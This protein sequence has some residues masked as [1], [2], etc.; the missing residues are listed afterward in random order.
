MRRVVVALLPCVAGSVYFFGWRSLVMVLVSWACAFAAEYLFCRW[1]REP[2]SEAV[3]V[4]ATILALIM[5]PSIPWHVLA[6]GVVFAVVVSKELFGGFGRNVFNPAMAGRCFVYVCFPIALTSTW[7]PPA[8]GPWGA[9]DRWDTADEPVAVT[10]ATPFTLIKTEQVAPTASQVIFGRVRGTMG[11]TCLPLILIGGL[12]L[13]VTRTANRSLIASAA[14]AYIAI[15]GGLYLLKVPGFEHTPYE[16]GY[17][18]FWFC[19]FFMVTDPITAPK[20]PAAKIIYPVLIVIFG[21]VIRKYS[22]FNGGYM[23]G[24]LLANTFVPIVDYSVKAL[25][26]R[27]ESPSPNP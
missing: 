11:M 27:K 12:Y 10:A 17:G 2:V 4:T 7:A 23:F 24:L 21:I 20:E 13:F 1:R 16:L 3:F 14:I 26:D 19:A 8:Q 15:S 6:V 25:R 5:P 22:V 18:A 9:L